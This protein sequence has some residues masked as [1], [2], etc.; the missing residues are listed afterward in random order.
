MLNVGV[1][2]HK[3]QM[4][5]CYLSNRKDPVQKEYRTNESGYE[6]FCKDIRSFK[7]AKNKIRI[8][9]ET[10]GNVW[11]FVKQME[12]SVGEIQ[13][14]NT[15]KFKVI[16]ESTSK[17]DKRDARTIAEYLQKDMLPTVTLP[18]GKSRSIA[19]YV[20]VR[21]RYVK[22]ST[23]LKN[24]IHA[25]FA[26]EGIQIKTADLSS[27]V[28]LQALRKYD[29]GE[30]VCFL[31]DGLVDELISMR[32]K[33]RQIEKKLEEITIDDRAVQLLRS[34]PGTGIVNACAVRGLLA[35]IHRFDDPKK[36]A[37]YAGLVPWVSNSNEKV[38]HGHIT[39]RGS[40]LLRNALVQMSMGMIRH[41]SGNLQSHSMLLYNWYSNIS[42]RTSGGKSKIALARKMAH[43]VWAMLI[44]NQ[45][46]KMDLTPSRAD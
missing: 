24:Q 18:D 37:S 15:M 10:T 32:S 1:D 22:L 8:G 5:V 17:T 2:L 28:K 23:R 29:V 16:V 41:W 7:L 42:S 30:D 20:K 4:T 33:I 12:S 44:N 14:I 35:N 39:K 34:I 26:E 9:V 13:V 43:I 21:D 11:F 40:T 19:K 3:T 6:A 27:N 38:R 45:E 31:L 36:V 46:F 25:L